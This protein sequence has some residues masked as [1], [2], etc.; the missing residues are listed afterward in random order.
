MEQAEPCTRIF[1]TADKT[2]R[3]YV[4]RRDD[5]TYKVSFE[6]LVAYDADELRYGSPEF[7]GYW[8]SYEAW[9]SIYDSVNTAM[10]AIREHPDFCGCLNDKTGNTS[11][12][13]TE[14]IDAAGNVSSPD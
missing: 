8:V 13:D 3:A 7:P 12:T 14:A 5:G 1:R 4:F 11:P 10:R 9:P 6:M 2:L